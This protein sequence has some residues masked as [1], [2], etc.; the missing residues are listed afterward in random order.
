MKKAWYDLKS[1]VT[2][3]V[4]ILFSYCILKEIVIPEELKILTT[5][6]VSFFLGSKTKKESEE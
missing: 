5:S 3:S 2:V 4:M 1:F 6:V